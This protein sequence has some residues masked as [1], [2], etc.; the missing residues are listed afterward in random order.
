M[1]VDINLTPT[2]SHIQI[3]RTGSTASDD[4]EL[5]K[6]L[7]AR[8]WGTPQ[9]CMAG[10]VL[11][12][13]LG[14][15]SGWFE[16]LGRR[17]RIRRIYSVSYDQVGFGKRKE[18]NFH[19]YHQWLNDLKLA[20]DFA[21]ETI[22]DKPIYI[23]GNSMGA[24]VSTRALG[25]HIVKPH[26][27]VMFSPG[28]DGHPDIFTLPFRVR[29]LWHALTAP[30]TDIV[31]PYAPEL[32]TRDVNVRNWILSDPERRF[33]VP[34]RMLLELLKITTGLDGRARK[35]NCPVLMLTAGMERIVNP[36]ASE[37][38]FNALSCT[39]EKFL[40]KDAWHDLMF[41]P[42][43]DELSD[44]VTKWVVQTSKNSGYKIGSD[45]RSTT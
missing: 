30:D 36:A 2:A 32:V 26:G 13:G 19:S 10:A 20:Y 16:A 23:M 44:Q 42:V 38:V 22:G 12:H 1:V 35:I 40:Y 29:S 25:D 21:R 31:L 18:E 28:F 11:V 7:P 14:A 9:D 33:T 4:S 5:A 39:K 45:T 6:P 17:L 8:T 34:A 15:H 27:F 43:I 3:P 37:R 41:D 24:V